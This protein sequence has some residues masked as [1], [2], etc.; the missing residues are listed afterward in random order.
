MADPDF[1]ATAGDPALARLVESTGFMRG[2]KRISKQLLIIPS[3]GSHSSGTVN[4]EIS[5]SKSQTATPC[6]HP[7]RVDRLSDSKRGGSAA[8]ISC[9]ARPGSAQAHGAKI[10]FS[11][12]DKCVMLQ[13]EAKRTASGK[14]A[15]AQVLATNGPDC[16]RA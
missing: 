15:R 9:R 13:V 5:C 16:P 3:G 2:G 8:W 4:K 12:K 10:R 7:I 11:A 6:V 14:G 1:H